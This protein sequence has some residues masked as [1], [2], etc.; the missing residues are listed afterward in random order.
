MFLEKPKRQ[1]ITDRLGSVSSQRLETGLTPGGLLKSPM[2]SKLSA[3][4]SAR[5]SAT[6]MSFRPDELATAQRRWQAR[7]L[8]NVSSRPP[9]NDLHLTR[10]CSSA[11]SAS[12]TKSRVAH[13]AMLRS[14]RSSVRARISFSARIYHVSLAWVISDYSSK[15]LNFNS[16]S[17]FRE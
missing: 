1:A 8:S 17:T 16:T 4:V 14:I 10:C 9:S 3:R 12:S 7:E 5:V 15:S 2:V 6:I 13:P 11:T